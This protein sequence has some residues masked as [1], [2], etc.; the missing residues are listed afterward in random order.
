MQ[1]QR[2][3]P[4][5]YHQEFPSGQPSKNCPNQELLKLRATIESGEYKGEGLKA[6]RDYACLAV[7]LGKIGRSSKSKEELGGIERGG[8]G[9]EKDRWIDFPS[10]GG[11]DRWGK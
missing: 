4:C 1:D 6:S 7:T 3:N 2:P 10:N 9:G 5:Q 8:G 11:P